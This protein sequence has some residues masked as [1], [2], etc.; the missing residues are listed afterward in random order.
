MSFNQV[1]IVIMA[2][3]IYNQSSSEITSKGILQCVLQAQFY[4]DMVSHYVI[5]SPLA[6]WI[7]L[8]MGDKCL[9]E[10]Y[11]INHLMIILK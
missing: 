10:E 1:N 9:F 5:I 11:Y 7:L 3:F 8:Q 4:N 6:G 2:N